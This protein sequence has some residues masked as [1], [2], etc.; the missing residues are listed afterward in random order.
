MLPP[1]SKREVMYK[2][3]RSAGIEPWELYA[4]DNRNDTFGAIDAGPPPL[5]YFRKD[6]LQK[7]SISKM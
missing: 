4:V 7:K 1:D 3:L 6:V 5:D 2:K